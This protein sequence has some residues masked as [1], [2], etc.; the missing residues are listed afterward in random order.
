MRLTKALRSLLLE[1]GGSEHGKLNLVRGSKIVMLGRK[2]ER[3]KLTEQR[4][5]KLQ[6]VFL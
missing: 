4:D 2:S 6:T 1:K 5:V 3:L